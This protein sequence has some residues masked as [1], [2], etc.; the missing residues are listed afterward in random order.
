MLPRGRCTN[1]G[2]L[3]TRTENLLAAIEWVGHAV[4]IVQ[5]HFPGWKF[6]LADCTADNGL[7]GRLV[8]GTPVPVQDVPRLA[9]ALPSLEV[10]LRR[11]DNVVDRGVG[12]NVLGSPLPA[13][14]HLLDVLSSQP[15]APPL[16]AG[17]IVTTGVITDAQPVSA[18]EVW[19]TELLG[20]P[21]RGLTVVFE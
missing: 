21:L 13:L 5:S 4:E 6:R 18:G 7:R 14:A 8:L 12:A 3:S 16:G 20:L 2:W 9:D 10:V 1:T 11:G 17:E 15:A 19:S